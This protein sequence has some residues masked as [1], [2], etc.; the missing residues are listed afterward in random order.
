MELCICIIVTLP[1]SLS[2]VDGVKLLGCKCAVGLGNDSLL[3]RD[4]VLFFF[5]AGE[6]TSDNV[7]MLK[8]H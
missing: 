7:K 8:S 6:K 3:T 2:I 5:F 4:N 1:S